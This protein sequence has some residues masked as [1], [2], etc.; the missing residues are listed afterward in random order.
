MW[1]HCDPYDEKN[2]RPFEYTKE[3]ML[4]KMEFFGEVLMEI[5]RKCEKFMNKLSYIPCQICNSSKSIFYDDH[6]FLSHVIENHFR[7]PAFLWTVVRAIDAGRIPFN[8]AIE[9]EIPTPQVQDPQPSTSGITKGRKILK[10]KRRKN[11][12]SIQPDSNIESSNN[13]AAKDSHIINKTDIPEPKPST[14]GISRPI[15][16]QITKNSMK[17]AKNQSILK[18]DSGSNTSN[19]IKAKESN[20]FPDQ[21]PNPAQPSPSV[22]STP[23]H[24][25]K[26]KN[27]MKT[28]K[29]KN[30]YCKYCGTMTSFPSRAELDQHMVQCHMIRTC[31]NHDQGCL[32]GVEGTHQTV[33]HSENKSVQT[34]ITTKSE[35]STQTGKTIFGQEI[36]ELEENVV[37][38][39]NER[40][41]LAQEVDHYVET[42]EQATQTE[43]EFPSNPLELQTL[44][45]SLIIAVNERDL[46]V[47]ENENLE[48]RLDFL[49]ENYNEYVETHERLV[50]DY[51]VLYQVNEQRQQQVQDEIELTWSF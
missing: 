14:S 20:E 2:I 51:E 22:I 17:T 1:N 32:C 46:F 12:S 5:F 41:L 49:T 50:E 3:E 8:P 48:R 38:A 30:H 21:I 10:P 16:K 24:I 19:E 29:N 15:Q 27:S 42:T 45:E 25:R 43:A 34:S 9:S 40:D 33:T 13:N 23:S 7:D 44:Q 28:A 35:R 6:S 4:P 37:I 11:E 47:E 18:P 36:H 26:T 39:I 31:T